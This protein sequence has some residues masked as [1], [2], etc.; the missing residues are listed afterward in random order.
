MS[1]KSTIKTALIVVI[2]AAAGLFGGSW[3]SQLFFSNSSPSAV[4][5]ELQATT[6][7]TP[8][9]LKPFSL[10]DQYGKP[11]TNERFQGKWSFVF[12]GYTNCPDVCPATMNLMNIVSDKLEQAGI[13]ADD[14]QVVFVSVDPDRDDNAQL[15]DYMKYFN[16]RF[17]GITGEKT[18]I[19]ILAKQLSAIYFVRKPKG[20]KPY[21]VDHSAAVLL[22]D[23]DGKFHALFTPPH[24]ADRISKDVQS[25]RQRYGDQ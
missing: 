4:S 11:F 23:P 24:D 19:D 5:D 21:E 3:L 1:Q 13:S 15:A 14:F 18:Q 20:D 12:F 22:I 2:V 9:P 7:P 10:H 17:I 16:P 8:R 6:F 25:I